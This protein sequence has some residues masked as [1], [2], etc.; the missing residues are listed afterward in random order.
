MNCEVIE[1][2]I[3]A[4]SLVFIIGAPTFLIGYILGKR[5]AEELK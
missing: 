2:F 4:I 1:R 5:M 3:D